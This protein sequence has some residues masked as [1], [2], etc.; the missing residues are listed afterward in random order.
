VL[1]LV[2][3]NTRT[4]SKHRY[5]PPSSR[6]RSLPRRAAALVGVLA[7][8][9]IGL[10]AYTR[11]EKP[12]EKAVEVVTVSR[13]SQTL[14]GPVGGASQTASTPNSADQIQLV[15]HVPNHV[16]P[17]SER[18]IP[19]SVARPPVPDSTIPMPAVPAPPPNPQTTP[20]PM[21]NPGGV[22]GSRP[23]RVLTGDI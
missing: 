3:K 13:P 20:P 7:S 15:R 10:V 6:R 22:N 17:A 16:P 14:G 23:E 1:E 19:V 2:M 4:I 11:H 18:Q 9:V 12:P 8:G 5:T 21:D